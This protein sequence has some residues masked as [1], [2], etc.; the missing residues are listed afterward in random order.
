MRALVC[1][2][3]SFALDRTAVPYQVPPEPGRWRAIALSALVHG[4]LLGLLWFSV[5]WQNMTPATVEAEIWS[6]QAREA[7]PPPPEPVPEP[8]KPIPE[9]PPKPAPAVRPDTPKAKTAD[10]EIALEQEKKRQREKEK[11]AEAEAERKHRDD[12]EKKKLAEQQKR[13]QQEEAEEAKRKQREEEQQKLA[14]DQKRKEEQAAAAEEQRKLA[15]EQKRKQEAEKRAR[16]R[17]EEDMRRLLS[18]AGDGTA[19]DSE[20]TAGPKS[21]NGYASLI[22][23]RIKAATIMPPLQEV[24]SNTP[25]EFLIELQPNGQLKSVD[26]V[27][28]SKIPAFDQAVR[29]AIDRAAPFP[30]DPATGKVPPSLSISHRP[31]D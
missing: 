3:D 2:P 10:P 6:P 17:R 9:P 28:S 26:M 24:S 30:P 20:K 4:V 23:N 14:E 22:A 18:Q 31:K 16:A 19:G 11:Q 12:A 27:R 5:S 29:R 7:A 8:P 21:D 25:V 13:K 15:E 1:L